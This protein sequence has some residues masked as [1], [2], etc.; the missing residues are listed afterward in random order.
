MAMESTREFREHADEI[1]GL[2]F[3]SRRSSVAAC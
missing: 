3:G 1:R 2:I